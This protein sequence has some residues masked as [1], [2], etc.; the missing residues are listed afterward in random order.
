MSGNSLP[1]VCDF[2]K[3]STGNLFQF[4]PDQGAQTVVLQCIGKNIVQRPAKLEPVNGI[5][6]PFLR[7]LHLQ[8]KP[9]Q[10]NFIELFRQI[11][12]KEFTKIRLCPVQP[13]V[14]M[15]RFAVLV[16]AVNQ[17]RQSVR[18]FAD[19]FQILGQLLLR[20][21]SVPDGIGVPGNH[22]YGGFQVVRDVREHFDSLLL[23]F[24]GLGLALG[25]FP[26]H[27]I[28]AFT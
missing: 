15:L 5:D 25:Q 10:V 18:L 9:G 28:K 23:Q 7:N 24:P 1:V 20:N 8:G 19:G 2:Q 16:E 11:F 22:R 13:E 6:D 26:C 17:L 27:F 14:R 21:F 3:H 12:P 4:H